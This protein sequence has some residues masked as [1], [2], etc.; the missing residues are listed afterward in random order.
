MS[1]AIAQF[2]SRN[3][4]KFVRILYVLISIEITSKHEGD[5]QGLKDW[6][7]WHTIFFECLAC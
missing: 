6:K 5:F 3:I 2:P 7:F 4:F 1:K